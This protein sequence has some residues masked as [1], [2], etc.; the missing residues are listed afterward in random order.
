MGF[1]QSRW[2]EWTSRRQ[3]IALLGCSTIVGPIAARTQEA[4]RVKRIGFLRV[5]TP[6]AAFIDG[7]RRGLRTQG[8]VEGQHFIIEYGL[9]Q[10]AAQIPDVAAELV[11]RRVDIIV[12]SG[13]PSVLPARDAAGS[14]PVVFVATLDPIATGLVA[15]LARPGRNVT[16]M[17]SISGDVIAKRLQMTRE[18]IPNLNKI[19]LL[20]RESSPTTAQYVQESRTAARNLGVEL[21]IEAERNPTELEGIFAAVRESVA[22]VVADDAEFTASRARIAELAL[23][24][25]LPTVSGLRELVEAGALMAY[26]ANFGELYRRAASHVYKILQGVKPADLPVEQPVKFE[27]LLNMRT[28]KAL[29]LHVPASLLA[30]AD[31]VIE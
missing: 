26:G 1:D 29:G 27:L 21:Q 13:T 11:R 12:A 7:F 16:G 25:R 10:S 4:D 15:S 22:L 9:A 8:L 3:I 19:V 5:G 28:A 20:V 30:L 6:P 31:E 24:S 2:R 14:I 17:T 18:L 23:R